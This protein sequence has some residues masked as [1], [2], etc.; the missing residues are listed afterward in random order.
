MCPCFLVAAPEVITI[1][2]PLALAVLALT[3]ITLRLMRLT[4][5][6][7][8]GGTVLGYR[9]FTGLPLMPRTDGEKRDVPER[10]RTAFYRNVAT[11]TGIAVLAAPTLTLIVLAGLVAILA[12]ARTAEKVKQHRARWYDSLAEEFEPDEPLAICGTEEEFE[13]IEEGEPEALA[14]FD[15]VE[16]I[17]VEAT[18]VDREYARL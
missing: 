18:R 6:A 13:D 9:W 5:L 7:T 16:A 11:A 3:G 15:T 14:P 1:V 10:L 4:G 12:G 8:I 17:Y 2:V